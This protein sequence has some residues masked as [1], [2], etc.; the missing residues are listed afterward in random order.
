ME[1]EPLYTLSENEKVIFE[2]NII[3]ATRSD[4][5]VGAAI[6]SLLALFSS[7]LPK[8]KSESSGV[9]VITNMRCFIAMENKQSNCCCFSRTNRFF[10]TFPLKSLNGFNGYTTGDAIKI[11]CCDCCAPTFN[12][13]IGIDYGASKFKVS[14]CTDDVD[15]HEEAQAIVAKLCELAQKNN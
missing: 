14:V 9:F 13:N 5:A 7:I 4:Q 2:L 15:K 10:W 8:K 3:S 12:F 6:F 1:K 11:C